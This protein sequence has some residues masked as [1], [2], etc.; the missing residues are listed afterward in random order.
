[1]TGVDRGCLLL[2]PLQL[3]CFKRKP[4]LVLTFF[5]EAL[6]RQGNRLSIGQ[7]DCLVNQVTTGSV[8]EAPRGSWCCWFFEG[9]RPDDLQHV[10]RE[11]VVSVHCSPVGIERQ[12]RKS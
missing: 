10:A 8:G 3:L 4:N 11:V 5:T 7:K 1:M 6:N 2:L 12:E 9:L